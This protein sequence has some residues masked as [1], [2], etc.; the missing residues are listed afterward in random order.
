MRPCRSAEQLCQIT[1]ASECAGSRDTLPGSWCLDTPE[2]SLCLALT[3]AGKRR[4]SRHGPPHDLT[5]G[6]AALELASCASS[7]HRGEPGEPGHHS[8]NRVGQH[9]QQLRCLHAMNAWHSAISC[10]QRGGRVCDQSRWLQRYTRLVLL[11][12]LVMLDCTQWQ[13]QGSDSHISDV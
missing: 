6:P 3:S 4:A 12:Q 5:Y 2:C 11:V 10:R 7:N 1:C 9:A 8:E 13:L